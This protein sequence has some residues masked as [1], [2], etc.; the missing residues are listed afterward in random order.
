MRTNGLET[1]SVVCSPVYIVPFCEVLPPYPVIFGEGI[2]LWKYVDDRFYG[3]GNGL[4][5]VGTDVAGIR[6]LL[7]YAGCK[8]GVP[9]KDYAKYEDGGEDKCAG[10]YYSED[11]H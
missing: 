3:K 10:E 7:D 2:I 4:Q 11:C 5:S 9:R 6:G 8:A 1:V